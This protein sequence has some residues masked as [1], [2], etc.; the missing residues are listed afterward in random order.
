MDFLKFTDNKRSNSKSTS[1]RTSTISAESMSLILENL[2]GKSQRSS[3]SKTYLGVWRGF[4]QFV[5]RLD[6]KPHRWEDRVSL[7][8]AHLIDGGMQ[9]SSIKSYKSAIKKILIHDGYDWDDNIILLSTLT[10]ACKLVNDTVKT[11]LP[12]QFGLLE[13][14]LFETQRIFDKQ[15]YL[16][17]M[18][19]ALYILGYYGLLRAGEL[20]KT[21][22]SDH[23]I[24]ACNVHSA[25]NKEK[26]LIVLYTSK[27]HGKDSYPQK[28]KITPSSNI[29]SK[30]NNIHRNFC[31]FKTVNT[32]IRMRGGFRNMDE[33]FFVFKDGSA[34]TT[35]VDRKV[36]RSMIKNLGLN[37][38]IYDLHSLRIGR[39]TDLVTKY[40]FSVTSVKQLRRWR[41]NEVFKYIR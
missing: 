2:K 15:L 19:K 4:N 3:T 14:I 10:R 31:P 36:L 35:G 5:I 22:D 18:Y 11:R 6:V 9:S 33:P 27:T 20:C 30:R 13:L 7:F 39:A 24:R 21:T 38:D 1:S 23:T 25:T 40:H 26:L 8:L 12:I 34:V 16:E 32:Y 37:P 28:I 29:C 17:V 41:S